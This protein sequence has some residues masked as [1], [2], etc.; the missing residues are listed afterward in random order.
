MAE[1]ILVLDHLRKSYGA[2]KV[3]DDVSLEIPRGELHALIGPNGA[4]KTTLVSEISGFVAP[5]SGRIL[6]GG[7]DITRLPAHWRAHHGLA[8]TFQITSVMAGFSVLENV[9]LSAQ[10]HSG[11]SFR[12]FQPASR[13]RVLNDKAMAALE[14][15]GLQGDAD[16]PAGILSHGEK[17]QLEL[18]MALAAEPDMLL[19]DEPMAGTGKDETERLIDTLNGLKGQYTILLVEHDMRA[20][21]ALADR[22][23]VLVYG[24]VIASGAP[25]A[26]RTD[27][28]VRNAY[29]GEEDA[30]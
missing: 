2:L 15:V 4:G 14:T 22:V 8:R 7:K 10:A 13:D 9:A 28:Q 21:F 27:P 17:R 3:T 29:L 20:V 23:S 5:D 18:A 19:L 25:E 16:R 6:F 12:F 26:I 1:P 30:A 11:T 24:Q